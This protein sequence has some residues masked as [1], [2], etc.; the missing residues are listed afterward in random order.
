MESLKGFWPNTL[1]PFE[2]LRKQP[3]TSKKVGVKGV[4]L[5]LFIT[6]AES[7]LKVG[8]LV[9]LWGFRVAIEYVIKITF[10]KMTL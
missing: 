5:A 7:C 10:R 3:G 1:P 6:E 2:Y 9:K 8:E 4:C